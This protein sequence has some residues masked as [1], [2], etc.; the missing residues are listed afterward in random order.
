MKL[1][2]TNIENLAN[3]IITFLVREELASD[4]SIYFNG[5]VMRSNGGYNDD[6]YYTLG[7]ETTE[8]VNPHDYF[9]YCAYDHILS[10]SF[11]GP[12]YD[13]LNYSFG[14]KEETFRKIFEK[15]GLYFELGNSWNLSVYPI[16]DDMEIEYTKYKRPK[17]TI[18]LSRGNYLTPS[19]L[20]E[21]MEKWYELSAS[22]GDKGSCVLGAGF[23]F[24]WQDEKYFMPACSPYQGS[25][26][27]EAHKDTVQKMLENIGATNI[28]YDWGRMD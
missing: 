25:I 27:W 7:W 12:L 5:K 13:L 14:R 6:G 19:E 26:S 8:N 24:E 2:K 21:I 22:K 20:F 4:V 10:M 18:Q 11:E 23:S 16:K 1:T 9:D 28:Q 17:K 15:Y 3:E